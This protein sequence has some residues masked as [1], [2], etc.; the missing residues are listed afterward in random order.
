MRKTHPHHARGKLQAK[1][2]GDKVK[3]T[4]HNARKEFGVMAKKSEPDNVGRQTRPA[5]HDAKQSKIAK[6]ARH[7]VKRLSNQV[8]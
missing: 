5:A 4:T 6:R 1:R 7:T 2:P 8:I 3:A